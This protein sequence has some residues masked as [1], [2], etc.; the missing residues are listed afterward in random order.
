[1]GII[2]ISRQFGSQ[3]NEIAK[4]LA[5]ALQY[6]LIGKEALE[7]VFKAHGISSDEIDKYDEKTPAFWQRFSKD[8]DSYL[9][10]LKLA[11]YEFCHQDNCII[12]GRGAQVILR[13]V[14]GVLR[15]KLMSPEKVRIDRIRKTCDCDE[16]QAVRIMSDSDNERSGYINFFHHRDWAS[17]DLYHL[18]VDTG[19]FGI[20]GTVDLV[21]GALQSSETINSCA[22]ESKQKVANLYLAQQVV[23]RILYEQGIHVDY[24]QVTVDEGV[25]SLRGSVI[26]KANIERCEKAA[27]SVDGID[28]ID[29]K[30]M[31][32][33]ATK[34]MHIV[35][36]Q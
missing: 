35:Y 12:L 14:P 8:K 9:D 36:R 20:K 34:D 31:Y 27:G 13:D 11:I 16:K 15:V 5:D 26:S 18:V 17:L 3:G 28:S 29:S 22:E 33:R 25:A 23:V 7:E 1:M 6:K 19:I 30:I 4:Q 24:L 21:K 10:N 2:T 32:I